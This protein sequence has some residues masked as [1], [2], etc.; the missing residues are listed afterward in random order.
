MITTQR[1]RFIC[2]LK[3]WHMNLSISIDIVDQIERIKK[4]DIFVI[5]HLFSEKV[6]NKILAKCSASPKKKKSKRI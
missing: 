4:I 1:K 5:D 6:L 3:K 2:F